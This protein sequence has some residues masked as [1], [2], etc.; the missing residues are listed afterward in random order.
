[1]YIY[2]RQQL[3]KTCAKNK[4]NILEIK[5]GPGGRAGL[6]FYSLDI[7]YLLLCCTISYNFH[8]H[9]DVLLNGEMLKIDILGTDQKDTVCTVLRLFRFFHEIC[10]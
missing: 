6:K 1:M 10:I 7:F 4:N 9:K 3:C 5:F 2:K 8:T